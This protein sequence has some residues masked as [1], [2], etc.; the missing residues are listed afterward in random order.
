MKFS[1]ITPVYNG[2]QFIRETLDSVIYQ[3]GDFDIEYIVIDGDSSD[4]TVEILKEYEQDINTRKINPKC[5]SLTFTWKSEKDNGMY[6]AINKGFAMATGDIYAYIN[7]DDLY[8]DNSF[9]VIKKSLETFPEIEW[10]KGVTSYLENAKY[11]KGSCYIYNQRWIYEGYYGTIAPFIQQDSVFWS[12]GLWNKIKPI[13]TNL[14][15]AGD[16]Y[17]WTS[18]AQHKP[19][20]SLDA[21]VSIFRKRRGQLSQDMDSYRIEQESVRIVHGIETYAI[22]LF[23]ILSRKIP[24]LLSNLLYR[25]F[26]IE[27]N[28]HYISFSNNTPIKTQAKSYKL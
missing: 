26:F 19:L 10:V 20:Y 5:N 12:K 15:L 13:D 21:K 7:A 28:Q 18:M 1:I 27:K 8:E 3:K 24:S 2:S 11:T 17:M 22:K 23:F 6:D 16:Y 25:L 14:R 4:N 9:N